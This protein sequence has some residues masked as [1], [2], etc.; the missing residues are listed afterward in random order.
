MKELQNNRCNEST[1]EKLINA[2]I[3]LKY[4]PI[5]PKT[6]LE[7]IMLLFPDYINNSRKE[8]TK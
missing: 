6:V 8:L 1:E 5:A 3:K 4:S 7:D 2:A